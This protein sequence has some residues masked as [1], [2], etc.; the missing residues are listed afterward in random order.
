MSSSRAQ[1]RDHRLTGILP[2]ACRRYQKLARSSLG[3]CRGVRELAKVAL[4]VRRKK[5]KRLIGRSSGF[6]EKLTVSYEGLD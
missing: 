3:A 5:T 1:Q 2:K 4:G 6:T